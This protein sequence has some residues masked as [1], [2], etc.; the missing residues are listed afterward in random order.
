MTRSFTP[1]LLAGAIL[2]AC[3]GLAQ[4][5]TITISC[6]TVGQDYE[7]CKR[8]TDEWAR[9]T[10]NSVKLVSIPTAP[11][12]IL[13]LYRK[14]FAAKSSDMDVVTLDVVWPGMIGNHLIDLTPYAKDEAKKHFPA[15]IANNTVK[16]KLVAMPW[17]TEAGMLYY[18]KDLLEKYKQPVP[19]TWEEFA[20][21]A[22]AIQEGERK[23]GNNDFQG[24]VW[25]GK[26][27]EG[28][29]CNALEWVYSDGGGTIVDEQ[30]NITINNE[31]AAKALDTAR[32]WIGTISPQGVLNYA[33][34]DAR[35]VF[36]NGKAA[37]MRNWSYAWALAQ[38]ADSRVKDKVGVTTMPG[39]EKGQ[40]AT[41]G[42][43]QLSVSKYSKHP[44][45]AADLV[46]YLTSER[47]QKRRAIEG[48]FN[49][50]YPALYEDKEVLAANPFF[51][52]L[53]QVLQ[54]ALPR[55]ATVTGL[56]YNE[57]SQSFWNATHE[58]LSGRTNGTD[59]VKK[60]EGRLKQ[61]KRNKW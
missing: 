40:A 45:E 18:R 11:S 30:G 54:N 41:L 14:L 50:T 27:Y 49:P 9:K 4:A 26:A 52:N 42:G 56:K 53:Y 23:A 59:A 17:F 35:G 6:G 61:V 57:V 32:G 48:S 33:E 19:K 28:L 55:P 34:E 20:K 24:Y 46:M 16:G 2:M 3:A 43:W 10:G 58:V 15:I 39:G 31:H 29:T 7:F 36:Q 12:D 38:G 44:D 25:Q 47:E 5:A 37:F 13:G 1:K 60:L 21:T 8:A 51:T 22:A